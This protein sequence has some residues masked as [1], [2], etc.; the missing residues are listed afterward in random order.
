MR[1]SAVLD[2]VQVSLGCTEPGAIALACALAR[3]AVGGEVERVSVLC[4]ANVFKNALGVGVPGADGQRGVAIAAALG[5]EAGDP[6]LRLKVL[7]AVEPD[8]LRRANRLIADGQVD[9][10]VDRG[11]TGIYIEATVRTTE[12]VGRAV[13]AGTHLGVTEITAN[14][15][16]AELPGWVARRRQEK[17]QGGSVLDGSLHDVLTVAEDLTSSDKEFLLEGVR[18][19]Q[20]AGRVGIEE[21]PGLAYGATMARLIDRGHLADDASGRAT[22]VA[23]AA[24]DARMSG[25]PVP[26]MASG[27][28]GNLGITATVP[29]AEVAR[30]LGADDDRLA[31]ALAVSHLV[32][33]YIK[34]RVGNLSA[35][36]GVYT[37]GA[38]GAAAGMI[39]LLGGDEAAI[40]RA[41]AL[42]VGNVSGVIC[43]GAKAG[44]ALKV[45]TASGL[46]VRTAYQAMQGT[47]VSGSDGILGDT[48]ERSVYNLARLGEG[49]R[50]ADATILDIM[51]GKMRDAVNEG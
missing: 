2:G 27:D 42:V 5:A 14:D 9:C 19:N 50:E 17:V 41:I 31:S 38:P 44:C 29:V 49:M 28:S 26:I 46:S 18:M 1:I 4:D 15:E 39:R 21:S 48:P 13:I 25:L 20:A 23:S 40:G 34:H 12:G 35:L 45:G 30:R 43:D 8:H 11:R 22:A 3:K 32:V 33:A 24:V 10:E 51:M 37:A 6:D 36:C 47:E 7:A 16:P